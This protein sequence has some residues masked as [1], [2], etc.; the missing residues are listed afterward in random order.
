LVIDEALDS[1]ELPLEAQIC[2]LVRRRG[3]PLVQVTARA[4]SLLACDRV[5]RL[6]AGRAVLWGPP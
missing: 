2:G 6:A 5:L 1:I 3:I 4:E